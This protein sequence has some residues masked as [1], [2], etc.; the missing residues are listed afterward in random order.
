[1]AKTE[2]SPQKRENISL[3]WQFLNG[4]KRY[5]AI[6]VLAAITQFFFGNGA[7]VKGKHPE[8]GVRLDCQRSKHLE[9][10]EAA[11]YPWIYAAQK[12]VRLRQRA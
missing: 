8:I 4:A 10:Y 6:T 11:E 2:K 3:L 1:M 5:F 7:D 12:D 9:V